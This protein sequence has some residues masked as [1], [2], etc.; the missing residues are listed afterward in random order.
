[1]MM[2]YIIRVIKWQAVLTNWL[3][4]NQLLQLPVWQH[5]I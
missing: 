4:P 5:K 1:M 3:F 2:W